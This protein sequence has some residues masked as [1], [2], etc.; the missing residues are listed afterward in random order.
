[1]PQARCSAGWAGGRSVLGSAAALATRPRW[2]TC[3]GVMRGGY[4]RGVKVVA[5]GQ[6][7][8]VD[9]RGTRVTSVAWTVA[10]CARL[11]SRRDALIVADAALHLGLCSIAE[12]EAVVAAMGRAK[13]V[14]RLRWVIANADP[15]AESAGE[16]WMRMVVRDLGY[17]VVSQFGVV[18]DGHR[19]RIDLLLEGSRVGLEFDGFIKY[20]R[21]DE[22]PEEVVA[23]T[24]VEEKR[25][26]ARIEGLGYRLLRVLWEQLF[27]PRGLDRR[28]RHALGDAVPRSARTGDTP[29][30]LVSAPGGRDTYTGERSLAVIPSR[31][32]S[33]T[34]AS[35]PAVRS[36]G[37]SNRPALTP[38]SSR[39]TVRVPVVIPAHGCDFG[40]RLAV[41]G[42]DRARGPRLAGEA[43]G[44][45]DPRATIGA[46]IAA[47]P[48]GGSNGPG[49]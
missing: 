15:R 29:G 28:I 35:A 9:N 23:R 30:R 5:G 43:H 42:P 20:D 25:R 24:V 4:G 11:L 10:D 18:A 44:R 39:I 22:D 1:M 21:A 19:H 37:T 7:V 2:F 31:R 6:A 32:G 40:S 47:P 46:W 12:L 34:V 38:R 36:A 48:N 3:R 41:A 13:R 45:P 49:S 17:S 33:P 8:L 16:T 27:D 26:Q 14:G